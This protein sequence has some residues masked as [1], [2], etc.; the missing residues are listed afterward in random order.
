MSRYQYQPLASWDEFERL[1]RDLFKNDWN[2]RVTSLNGRNGSRQNGVDIF[3]YPN[4][5]K[6]I[7]GVQC[8]GKEIYPEKKI[9]IDQI[10]GEIDNALDFEP[11][12]G[13]YIFATT[14]RREVKLQRELRQLVRRRE[15]P[16]SVAIIF[17]DDI[18]NMIADM[19]DV[20]SKYYPK[21]SD[22][23]E[24]LYERAGFN[25][26][27]AS[28][29]VFACQD[30]D[31][32]VFNSTLR[33]LKGYASDTHV[34]IALG[35][36]GYVLPRASECVDRIQIDVET[37]CD[38]MEDFHDGDIVEYFKID[39]NLINGD[40]S[41][42]TITD[43]GYLMGHYHIK[44]DVVYDDESFSLFEEEQ[45]IYMELFRVMRILA[46]RVTTY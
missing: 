14:M 22:H 9:T 40:G 29:N 23:T 17:W 8:K 37:L 2:S 18:E 5:G 27:R 44:D 46:Q 15:L 26:K 28:V 38:L 24:S 31:E 16:F 20:E 13:H 11:K 6:E 39:F 45:K 30:S 21:H 19:P 41:I 35:W 1:C 25:K 7:W 10:E 43:S 33:D 32:F 34:S 4:C 3:G 42:S 36:D 12:L